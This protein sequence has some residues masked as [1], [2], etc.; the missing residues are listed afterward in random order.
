MK[1]LAKDGIPFIYFAVNM[2]L[3]L[4]LAR[5][6]VVKRRSEIKV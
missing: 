3:V 6:A 5:S 1:K 4:K 2:K